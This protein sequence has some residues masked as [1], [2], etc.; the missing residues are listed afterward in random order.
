MNRAAILLERKAEQH[1][2]ILSE[3]LEG[4]LSVISESG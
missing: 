4:K 1:I 2:N 3:I